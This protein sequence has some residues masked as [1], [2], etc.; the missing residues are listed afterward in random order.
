LRIMELM[1]EA[2]NVG[3]KTKAKWERV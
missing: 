1:G 2:R 3:V